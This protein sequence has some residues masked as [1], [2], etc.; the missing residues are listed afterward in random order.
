M[1]YSQVPSSSRDNP[2][3]DLRG[4]QNDT[5]PY[6]SAS[7]DRVS[8]NRIRNGS[9]RSFAP[10]LLEHSPLDPNELRNTLLTKS[11]RESETKTASSPTRWTAFRQWAI[12][13]W[14]WETSLLFLS[15]AALGA[16]IGVLW[17]YSGRSLPD[18][19]S[20]LTL[21]ALISLL[22]AISTSALLSVVSNVIGQN[23][24][25]WLSRDGGKL[26]HL[27]LIDDASRGPWG[28]LI[29]LAKARTL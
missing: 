7:P 24:W 12:D 4:M 25:I 23:K 19:P 15:A 28:S 9:E 5:S 8:M 3:H 20:G 1:S 18:W 6:S 26:S 22:S 2:V 13:L 16:Q 21:N 29:Y 17:S 14:F 27:E 11:M 10:T